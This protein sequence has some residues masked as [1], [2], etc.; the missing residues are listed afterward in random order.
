M[1]TTVRDNWGTSFDL[2]VGEIVDMDEA[3]YLTSPVDSPF[4]TGVDSDGLSILSSVPA[5]QRTVQWQ[6]DTI[7]TPK[8]VLAATCTASDTACTVAAGDGIKFE[9]N[10]VI[11]LNG[12]ERALITAI[13]VDTLTIT[14]GTIWGTAAIRASGVD[15]LGIGHALPEG[16][17]PGQSRFVDRTKD[18]NFTQIFGP[19]Q[20]AMSGTEQVVP[21][22]GVPDEMARQMWAR[23]Q[24]HTIRREQAILYGARIEDTT[25]ERRTMGGLVYYVTTN[26]DSS[27]TVLNV[28]NVQ[29]N[30]QTLYNA[31]GQPDRLAANPIALADV[32]EAADTSR[33]RMDVRDTI[34]GR[35]P[36][37]QIYTEFG[38]LTIVRNRWIRPSDAFL[39]QRDQV[40]RRPLR[41]WQLERLGKVG[42][43]SAMMMLCEESLEVKGQA[44]MARFSGLVYS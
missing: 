39:F 15:V 29:I 18:Y 10:D 21:R 1:P 11:L 12:I 5:T 4:L 38:P 27:H 17:A 44:H 23:T 35:M 31:G 40:I 19:S 37:A 33:V 16:S 13:A 8:T 20:V 36:A 6:H 3:I 25:A 34:R 43:R 9:V 7:L 28:A 2:T 41:P 14:R 22:Y 32:N 30:Q 42:D 26:V 24:E